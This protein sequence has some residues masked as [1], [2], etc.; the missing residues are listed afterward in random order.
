MAGFTVHA[1]QDA[2]PGM[3]AVVIG[4]GRYPRLGGGENPVPDPDGMMQLSSPPVS[5]RALATW[6]LAEYRDETKP[7]RSVALLLSEQEPAPFVDPRTG[8][9][10]PVAEADIANIVAAV[11]EWK[12]RGDSDPGNRLVFYFCGHGVSQGDDMA[13]LAS[14]VFADED[15]PLNGALDFKNLMNGL[16][17]CR[18]SQ[19][20]FFVDACRASSDV[21][22]ERSGT[23]AGQVPLGPGMRPLDLPRRL[24]V[25]YYAT[26]AGDRSH[27]RPGQ[28]SLFTEALLRSLRGAGSDD[29]EGDWRVTTTRLQEAIDHFMRQPQFA[30]AIAG[31]QVPT[32]GELPV[33]DLHHLTGPP[34]VPVY[35]GLD[36]PTDNALAEFVCRQGGA[37][38]L[39]RR[40]VDAGTAP[41]GEPLFGAGGAGG[42]WSIE[43]AFGEYEFEALLGELDVRRKL[44]AVRP[45]YRRIRLA[46]AV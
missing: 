14:D 15:N 17:R 41:A 8:T 19:Q 25:P 24:H 3:H 40:P 10:H 4:V 27:G 9:A 39:R 12:A 31:V 2:G 32:V 6:L 5:A 33:F 26:L 30:G 21:L 46:A 22:I 34:V 37:E 18:A 7:L 38:R 44:V 16:K 1:D 11:R 42:E 20:V 23:F 13:L 35:V 43:L 45:A 29:P 36:E 28:V